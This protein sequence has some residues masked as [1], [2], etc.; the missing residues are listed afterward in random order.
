MEKHIYIFSFHLVDS[1]TLEYIPFSTDLHGGSRLSCSNETGSDVDS[2]SSYD[3]TFPWWYFSHFLHNLWR[4]DFGKIQIGEASLSWW[5]FQVIIQVYH[6]TSG[7][8]KCQEQFQ[9]SVVLPRQVGFIQVD[10]WVMVR[11]RF[12]HQNCLHSCKT[13][14][15]SSK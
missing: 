15:F 4:A 6:K 14:W 11:P 13:S 8:L 1:T 9:N 12:L 5:W 7:V 3:V 2:T 10:G